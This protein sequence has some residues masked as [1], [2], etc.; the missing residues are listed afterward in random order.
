MLI[1]NKNKYLAIFCFL[2]FSLGIFFLSYPAAALS[3]TIRQV[4]LKN[5]PIIYFLNH[6]THTRKAYVNE[7]AYLSYGNKWSELKI[8]S[9]AELNK[10][11]ETV[12]FKTASSSRV[13]Y[14]R[15]QQK[16]LVADL[17]DLAK[18]NLRGRPILEVGSV[19]LDQY[20]LVSYEEIGL[21][22]KVE[23]VI[24][25]TST[26]PVPA[27][28]TPPLAAKL[29]VVSEPVVGTSTALG[30]GAVAANTKSNLLG[31]FDFGPAVSDATISRLVFDLAGVYD[32]SIIGGLSAKDAANFEYQ[33]ANLDWRS[34]DRQIIFN[35]ST[36]LELPAGDRKTIKIYADL[37]GCPSCTNQTFH[38]ELKNQ[39]AASSSLPLS[40]AWPLKG[41]VFKIIDGSGTFAQVRVEEESLLGQ[42]L[43]VNNGGR[44]IGKFKI[45]EDSG[46]EQ[47][48]I[49]RLV[50]NNSG[51]ANKND[52]N[53]FRLLRDG[54][55]VA[56]KA[57]LT[58]DGQI[59][60]SI[61][62]L[63]VSSSSPAELTVSA[64]LKSGYSTTSGFNL[65]LNTVEASGKTYKLML[66]P[67]INN[68]EETYILN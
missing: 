30:A 55:V 33:N 56:R 67:K 13:Y 16:A 43:A 64:D 8:I 1:L 18:F 12:L 2:L 44:F 59:D 50:F 7:A 54:V 4:K 48:L 24:V 53:N 47:A 39:L 63:Q 36:P 35:F 22:K 51:S 34:T 32:T 14:I 65:E 57:E 60:F 46:R 26:D 41:T 9:Q 62:S 37:L 5:S 10:W 17:I 49:K 20:K 42:N 45:F 3:Q 68:L 38:L 27:T 25:P 31:I 15:G 19:D 23:P 52:W 58:S 28:T 6:K 40:A 61:N 66:Y 21:K 11:P 29:V